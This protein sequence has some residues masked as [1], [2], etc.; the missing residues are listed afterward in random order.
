MASEN[1]MLQKCKFQM[2]FSEGVGESNAAKPKYAPQRTRDCTSER[3]QTAQ[4]TR[5]VS[6]RCVV[7][8]EYSIV[9]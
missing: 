9:G 1:E 4:R 2:C 3:H 6:H 8:I 7:S 5:S